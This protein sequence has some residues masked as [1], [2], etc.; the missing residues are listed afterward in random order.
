MKGFFTDGVHENP[1]A[2]TQYYMNVIDLLNRGRRIW[3]DVPKETRGSVF[4]ETFIMGVR[5]LHLVS[6]FHVGSALQRVGLLLT[7]S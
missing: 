1:L 3:S 6:F 5:L 4:E 7:Y 2:A